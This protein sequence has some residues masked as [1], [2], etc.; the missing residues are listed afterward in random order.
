MVSR[1]YM[2]ASSGVGHSL[3]VG[4]QEIEPHHRKRLVF[5]PLALVSIGF[6]QYLALVVALDHAKPA[7]PGLGVEFFHIGPASQVS[8]SFWIVALT[9][10]FCQSQTKLKVSF[11]AGYRLRYRE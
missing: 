8:H 7:R 4:D 10:V 5:R 3:L 6:L 1:E 2:L 9:E 11:N